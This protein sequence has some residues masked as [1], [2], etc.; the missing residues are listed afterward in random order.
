MNPSSQ[1]GDQELRE[2]IW[3][4]VEETSVCM[5]VTWDGERQRARPETA[6]IRP[7]DNA[8][9]FLIDRQSTA[10]DQI[11]RFPIITLTFADSRTQHYLAITGRAS[12]SDDREKITELFKGTDRA[13]FESADDP[14]ICLV[15][16]APHD[17]ELWGSDMRHGNESA[18][19]VASVPDQ[20]AARNSGMK[21]NSF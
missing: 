11:E 8:I 1:I 20:E 13:W 16:V 10:D 19:L 7:D 15:T 6:R 18:T 3:A 14:N 4:L 9:Y 5:F 21:L 2:R 12:V 17:A